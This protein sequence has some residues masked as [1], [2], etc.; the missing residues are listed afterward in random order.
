MQPTPHFLP[1]LLWLITNPQRDMGHRPNSAEFPTLKPD[2]VT[3]LESAKQ[4][5]LHEARELFGSSQLKTRELESLPSWLVEEAVENEKKNWKP[6]IERLDRRSLAPDANVISSHD[7]CTIKTT[8]D[9]S[10]LKLK[11]RTVPHRNRDKDKDGTRKDSETASFIITRFVFALVAVSGFRLSSI[12]VSGA[13]FQAD[14]LNRDVYMLPPC[15]WNEPRYTVFRLKKPAYGLVESGRLWQLAIQ[16]W[17]QETG[18]SKLLGFLQIFVLYDSCGLPKMILAKVVDDILVA[19][20]L[21]DM[22]AFFEKMTSKFKLSR[23]LCDVPFEFHS[24]FVQQDANGEI[25]LSISAYLKANVHCIS[26]SKQ[27]KSRPDDLCA[28]EFHGYVRKFAGALN[29]LGQAVLPQ[30]SFLASWS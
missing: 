5:I 20:S 27:Q 12:D 4:D 29:Y 28:P 14:N 3:R 26:L 15:S 19:G 1:L 24:L 25:T 2:A 16:K 10:T 8:G 13:Y 30:A 6:H 9:G 18:F 23:F 21:L 11:N 22:H 7:F 17:L